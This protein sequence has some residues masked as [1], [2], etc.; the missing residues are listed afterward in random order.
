MTGEELLTMFC[1]LR[2]IPEKKIPHV[3]KTEIKRLDLEKYAKKRCG[4]YSGG[5]KR[6]LS[7]AIALVG[8]P[9]IILLDEPT[10]GMDPNARR[11]LWNAL[12]ELV[13]VGKSIVLTSHSM[14]ECEALCTR[15][16]I[17]VNGEFKSLGSAQ[18]LKNKFGKGYT[19]SLC[20]KQGLYDRSEEEYP[21]HLNH[22]DSSDDDCPML[23]AMPSSLNGMPPAMSLSSFRE[24]LKR[25]MGM[26]ITFNFVNK[27]YVSLTL[28][29]NGLSWSEI[30]RKLE[31]HKEYLGIED[32]SVS[33]TTLEQVFLDMVK[34][35]N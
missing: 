21:P 22:T 5:N 17:M 20:M 13:A 6:K 9:P 35:G 27:K 7:T 31:E 1:R 24:C 15:L 34:Y 28:P 4:T 10:T 19:V 3:V 12:T 11:H 33:Q 8:S 16:A 2:G 25:T 32:Y 14:E 30:F 26:A 23:D 29:S 18:H